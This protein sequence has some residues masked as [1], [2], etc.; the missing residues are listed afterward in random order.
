MTKNEPQGKNKPL[1]LINHETKKLHR[2]LPRGWL[3]WLVFDKV[4]SGCLY[5]R[6]E[7]LLHGSG[8]VHSVLVFE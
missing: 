3:F 6:P 5:S 1:K 8:A 2:S 4:V 7:V